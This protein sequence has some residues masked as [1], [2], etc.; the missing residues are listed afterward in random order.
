MKRIAW[1][2]QA[3]ADLRSLDKPAAMRILSALHRFAK[4]GTGDL[5]ALQGDAEELRLRIGDYRLFFVYTDD[6][7][8]E[9]RR[10]RHRK[11]AYR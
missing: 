10:V 8:I 7:A 11:E 4:S 3:K 2:E 9:I 5:K 1:T 6:E